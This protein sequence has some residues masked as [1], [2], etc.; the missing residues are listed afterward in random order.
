MSE[1]GPVMIDIELPVRLALRAEGNQWVAY[2]ASQG[3]M[4]DAVWL[5][6]IDLRVV[7]KQPMLKQQFIDLMTNV[8]ALA[9]KDVMG[10][11]PEFAIR[12]A[13]ESERAGNA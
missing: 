8:I 1:K 9:I 6:A 4:D 3:T 5:G 11:E 12:D 10:Q 2:L 13:P 7:M